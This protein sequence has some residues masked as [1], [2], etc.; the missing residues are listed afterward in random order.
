MTPIIVAAIPITNDLDANILLTYLEKVLHGLLD[1]KI[2]VISY[3]CDGTEVE[4]SIQKLLVGK[5]DLDSLHVDQV[6]LATLS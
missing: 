3:A 5:V 1:R 4:R 2:Q 6:T